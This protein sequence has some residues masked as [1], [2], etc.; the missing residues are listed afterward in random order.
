MDAKW[1]ALS[2]SPE[3]LRYVDECTQVDGNLDLQSVQNPIHDILKKSLQRAH[4]GLVICVGANCEE[5]QDDTRQHSGDGDGSLSSDVFH[6]DGV[7][8]EHRARDPDD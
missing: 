2:E 1:L 4:R 3:T 5:K 8:G 7:P 6:V